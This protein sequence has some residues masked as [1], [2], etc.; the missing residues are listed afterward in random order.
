[1]CKLHACHLQESSRGV[2]SASERP[3]DGGPN[4]REPAKTWQSRRGAALG[5]G[6]DDLMAHTTIADMLASLASDPGRPRL[7]WYGPENE[8]IE[9]SGAVLSNWVTKTTNLLVEEFDA[10]PAVVVGLD[11]PGHWRTL[12]WSLAVWRSGAELRLISPREGAASDLDVIVTNRPDR[13]THTTAPLVAVALPALARSFDGDLASGVID[14]ASAVMTYGDQLGF[15]QETDPGALAL[16]AGAYPGTASVRYDD[17]V[18]W[19]DKAG[20]ALDRDRILLTY[21][22]DCTSRAVPADDPRHTHSSPDTPPGP[23]IPAPGRRSTTLAILRASVEAWLADGSVVLV[24]SDPSA[25][26]Q[27]DPAARDNLIATER[28]GA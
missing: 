9:L 7:T 11:L 14:A 17:L 20:V 23:W 24:D 4:Q 28:I 10:G 25:R 3:V 27:T 6:Y 2:L 1:M 5:R 12:V 19:A 15:V 8:R 21:D 26:L 18:D 22:G 16:G 13:W